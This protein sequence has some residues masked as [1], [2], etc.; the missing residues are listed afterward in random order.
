MFTQENSFYILANASFQGNLFIPAIYRIEPRFAA[1]PQ[2][3]VP[4]FSHASVLNYPLPWITHH[5]DG[6]L[7]P[8]GS[9]ATPFQT[10][11]KSTWVTGAC[12]SLHKTLTCYNFLFWNRYGTFSTYSI[13]V[14]W[15]MFFIDLLNKSFL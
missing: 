15:K 1:G 12:S 11:L 2:I 14:Y 6:V 4:L 9:E 7:P 3:G 13:A 10:L 8:I 5:F